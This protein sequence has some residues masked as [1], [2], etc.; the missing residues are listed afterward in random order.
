MSTSPLAGI[1]V[2]DL[3]TVVVGPACTL[4]LAQFGC[5]VIKVETAEGDV[6]RSL[7]GASPGGRHSGAYLHLNRGKRNIC[8]NLKR[9]AGR[10]ALLRLVQT[11]DVLVSNMRPEALARL[12]LDAETLR[13]SQPSLIHCLI[14][15]FGPGGPYRGKP[16]YDSVIQGAAGVAALFERRDGK[17]AYVPL[18]LCDHITG[19]ITASA[20]IAALFERQSTGTGA[21]IEVPMH[22]TMS[23]FVLHEHLG[24]QSFDPPIGDIG[25]TRTL[26]PANSPLQTADGWISL[27]A[28][29]DAQ[30]S[31]FFRAVGREDLSQDPR[32][33]TVADR[34]SNVRDWFAIRAAVVR[35]RTTA[36]WL[37]LFEAADV[38][39][40]PCHTLSTL[41]DDPHLQAVGLLE[42][43]THPTEGDIHAIRS[44][45]LHDGATATPGLA[46]RPT[47]WDTSRVLAD[48]GLTADEIN[49][50]LTDGA[51]IQN[52]Q[53]NKTQTGTSRN[54]P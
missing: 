49:A 51:A 19:E 23:A 9:P 20:I 32:F 43:D 28:N 45:I 1:R 44:T 7:G 30:V 10:A 36:E 47:G 5:E 13:A 25:D 31:A 35:S 48:A 11:C 42:G 37:P 22:E 15:G 4:R 29:T 34:I 38:P 27:T 17:P 54:E 41:L 12:G 3:T 50:L 52:D 39:A 8:L 2:A 40:M 6:M 26:D 16:A 53:F 24:R 14:T 18:L 33:R 46:A 21:A